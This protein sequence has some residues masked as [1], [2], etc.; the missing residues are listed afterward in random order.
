MPK[1][2]IIGWDIG[3]AHLKAARME[4]GRIVAALQVALPLWQALHE[5]ER[6]FDQAEARIGRAEANAVTM[7]GELC[8]IVSTHAEGVAALVAV[9]QR[10]LSGPMFYAGRAGFVNAN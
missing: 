6:A 1:Q 3:G 2:S 8:D 9:A 4:G 7:T 10:R 5:A